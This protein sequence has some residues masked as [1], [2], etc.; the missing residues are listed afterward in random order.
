MR[1][2]PESTREEKKEMCLIKE[3]RGEKKPQQVIAL[4]CD[5]TPLVFWKEERRGNGGY[6]TVLKLAAPYV[7]QVFPYG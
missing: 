4:G 6:T 2:L 7:H 1:S 3:N 5:L